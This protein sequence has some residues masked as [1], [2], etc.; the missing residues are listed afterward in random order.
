MTPPFEEFESPY[1]KNAL[2]NLVDIV[3]HVV[4]L[5]KNIKVIIFY[6]L[7]L[8]KEHGPPFA[9]KWIP[10][11]GPTGML[12]VKFGWNC[13]SGSSMWKVYNE[14]NNNEFRK[15]NYLSP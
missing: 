15:L 5:E 6:C 2:A 9:Y 3:L 1:F 4:V 11:E 7:P 12:C 8:A 10:T 14:K 13:P